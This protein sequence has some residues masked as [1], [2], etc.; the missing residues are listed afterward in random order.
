[1]MAVAPAG[2]AKAS[3]AP[4]KPQDQQQQQSNSLRGHEHAGSA[5]EESGLS[6][7]ETEFASRRRIM[8]AQQAV[9]L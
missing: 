9:M 2:S 4:A 6:Q 8:L 1:M 7:Q 5:A 3:S